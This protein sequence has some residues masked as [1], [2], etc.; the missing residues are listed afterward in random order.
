[1][2][3]IN[4]SQ[5]EQGGNPKTASDRD[6]MHDIQVRLAARY[7]GKYISLPGFESESTIQTSMRLQL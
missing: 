4:K 3:D 6:H 5:L 7:A 2:L 1:M